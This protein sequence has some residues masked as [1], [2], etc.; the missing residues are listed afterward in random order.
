M[1][2][3]AWYAA[4]SHVIFT[5]NFPTHPS[6]PACSSATSP[7]HTASFQLNFPSSHASVPSHTPSSSPHPRPSSQPAEEANAPLV[8]PS[9]APTALGWTW[10]TRVRRGGL[11]HAR[12]PWRCGLIIASQGDGASPAGFGLPVPD[13]PVLWTR[14]PRRDAAARTGNLKT[15]VLLQEASKSP[16]CICIYVHVGHACT[17]RLRVPRE[18]EKPGARCYDVKSSSTTTSTPARAPSSSAP[19]STVSHHARSP[20]S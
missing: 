9:P 5:G 14:R 18:H 12:L 1:R 13:V 7:V 17:C 10:R 4:L 6:V 20:C 15:P 19:T 11:D 3:Y 16:R 2:V 8:L